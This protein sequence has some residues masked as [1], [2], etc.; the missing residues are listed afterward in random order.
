MSDYARPLR[1]SYVHDVSLRGCGATTTLSSEQAEAFAMNPFRAGQAK[2]LWGTALCAG[3]G[4]RR[5]GKEFYWTG[6]TE[7]VG[8]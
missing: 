5:S 6:T 1:D 7:K 3:C 4:Q 2:P 8:T